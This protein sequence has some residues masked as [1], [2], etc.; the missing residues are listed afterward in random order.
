MN[1][2]RQEEPDRKE[3]SDWD[4]TN[5]AMLVGEERTLSMLV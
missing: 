2:N 3:E 4:K 1:Y 5:E